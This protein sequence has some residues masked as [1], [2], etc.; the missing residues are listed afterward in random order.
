MGGCSPFPDYA[1]STTTTRALPRPLQVFI[2]LLTV[3]IR[4]PIFFLLFCER[5]K[6]PDSKLGNILACTCTLCILRLVSCI[7]AISVYLARC[8]SR[9]TFTILCL[10]FSPLLLFFTIIQS[11]NGPCPLLRLDI[12]AWPGPSCKCPQG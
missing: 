11:T 6:I 10:F 4:G 9:M 2:G 3:G 12:L 8:P 1:L 5:I 7:L